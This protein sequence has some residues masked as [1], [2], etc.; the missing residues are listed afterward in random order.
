[1]KSGVEII[2][3]ER[4]KQVNK[5]GYSLS[6]DLTHDSGQ[7]TD[8]AIAYIRFNLYDSN[9]GDR[10]EADFGD[11]DAPV[12]MIP[13]EWPFLPEEFHGIDDDRITQLAKAGAFIAAEIDRLNGYNAA[14]SEEVHMPSPPNE[15]SPDLK[16]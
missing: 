11:P 4:G 16:A 6:H 10:D 7:L 15:R 2:G 13:S 14:Y 9:E 3:A 5:H 12:V 1:M 8:A